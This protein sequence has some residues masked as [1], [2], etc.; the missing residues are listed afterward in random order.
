MARYMVSVVILSVMFAGCQLPSTDETAKQSMEGMLKQR[1]STLYDMACQDFAA[2]DLA[3]A[4]QKALEAQQHDKD[5]ARIRMLLVKIYIESG[6]YNAAQKELRILQQQQ[7]T[8]AKVYYLGGVIHQKQGNLEEALANYKLSFQQNN[9]DIA[10]V[11]AAAEVMVAMGEVQQA[12]DYLQR[13]LK[14]AEHDPGAYEVAGRIA[15]RLKEPKKAINH[16]EQAIALDHKNKRYKEMLA[17]AYFA[18]EDYA[19]A[20]AIIE[21]LLKI[22]EYNP[23]GWILAKLG[24]SDYALGRADDAVNAFKAATQKSPGNADYWASLAKANMLKGDTVATIKAANQA[25]RIDKAHLDASLLLGLALIRQERAKEALR[26][27]HYA[28]KSHPKVPML[29][30]LLG[31]AYLAIGKP[32]KAKAEQCYEYALHLDP[33]NIVA[34][35]QLSKL[36][37][38]KTPAQ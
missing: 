12:Q 10:P 27:L 20:A 2:G 38:G 11:V 18:A 7:P 36:K 8:S 19:K 23:P 29:H 6:E 31:N 34:Q 22:K 14:L 5:S 24:D 9:T 21:T 30:C 35:K 32:D 33:N 28:Q 17:T 3:A 25:R 1:A 15:M 16:F 13:H 26:V 4:R 37:A